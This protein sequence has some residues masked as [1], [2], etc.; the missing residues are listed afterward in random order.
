MI[1]SVEKLHI[2]SYNHANIHNYV[3]LILVL[4]LILYY[5]YTGIYFML[6]VCVSHNMLISQLEFPSF[7]DE[8]QMEAGQNRWH[9]NTCLSVETTTKA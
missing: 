5:T 2:Q 9:E 8:L 4:Y 6:S 1:Y 7:H 3:I